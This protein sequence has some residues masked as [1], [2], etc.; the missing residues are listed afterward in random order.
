MLRPHDGEDAEL[1]EVRLPAQRLEDAVILLG[2]E[3]MLGHHC[4]RDA[5]GFQDVH[6]RPLAASA[7]GRQFATSGFGATPPTA[8]WRATGQAR[9][10]LA[11]TKPIPEGY[12]SVT[13]YLCVRNAG[14]ALD[15]Y[16]RALGAKEVMRFEH[17]GKVGH[18]E[19]RIGNSV[20]MLSDEWTEGGHLS[21]QS[22]GG[23]A[24]S[25]HIYVDAVDQTF[26]RAIDAPGQQERAVQDQFYGDRSGTL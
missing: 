24:V 20:V 25:L 9:R 3:T 1:D 26:A 13:P 2:A 22:L 18:A 5:G 7:K 17:G 4:G 12:H 15:W 6:A 14:E 21:P 23:T 19:I 8:V 16:G 11:M 10:R